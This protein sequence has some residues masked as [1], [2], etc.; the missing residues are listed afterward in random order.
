M[1]KAISLE[2]PKRIVVVDIKPTLTEWLEKKPEAF[3]Y[4]QDLIDKIKAGEF[5]GL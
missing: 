5:S 4:F 3:I 1:K 2:N